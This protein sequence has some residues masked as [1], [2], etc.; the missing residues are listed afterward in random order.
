MDHA[1]DSR[2]QINIHDIAVLFVLSGSDFWGLG[3]DLVIFNET[4]A[5]TF[6]QHCILNVEREKEREQCSLHKE[7][8]MQA[9]GL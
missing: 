8:L 7:F 2:Q 9:T 1:A 4:G 6:S 3:E 5:K